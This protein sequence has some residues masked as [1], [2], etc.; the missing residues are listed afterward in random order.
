MKLFKQKALTYI[1]LIFAI[2]ALLFATTNSRSVTKHNLTIGNPVFN[3]SINDS[4][5][6]NMLVAIYKPTKT[7]MKIFKE[8]WLEKSAKWSSSG[9]IINRK[10]HLKLSTNIDLDTTLKI[11]DANF[12]FIGY[13]LDSRGII[14]ITPEDSTFIK[15]DTITIKMTLLH[16]QIES[17]FI[18]VK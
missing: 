8:I 5:S 12:R 10:C 13:G 2:F 14:E 18:K 6:N 15:K 16:K 1:L 11:T 3:E 7:T 4:K 9:V 17:T